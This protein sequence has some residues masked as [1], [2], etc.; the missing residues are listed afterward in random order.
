MFVK[1][2]ILVHYSIVLGGFISI[3]GG[4][5]SIEYKKE[6]V[7]WTRFLLFIDLSCLSTFFDSLTTSFFIKVNQVEETNWDKA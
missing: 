4:L 3:L 5:P 7:S 6:N 2:V 1:K